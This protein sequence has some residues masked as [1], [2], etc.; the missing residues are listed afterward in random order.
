MLNKY[1]S[2]ISLW[3]TWLEET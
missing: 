1:V 3:F 2:H